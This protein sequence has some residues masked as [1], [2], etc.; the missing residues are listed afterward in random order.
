MTGTPVLDYSPLYRYNIYL[1]LLPQS[2]PSA[3]ASCAVAQWLTLRTADRLS[4]I[5]YQLVSEKPGMKLVDRLSELQVVAVKGHRQKDTPCPC[6][7][8]VPR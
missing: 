5:D 3:D 1:T 7:Y 6:V 4:V 2:S 8:N